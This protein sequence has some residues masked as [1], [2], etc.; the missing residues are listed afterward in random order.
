MTTTEELAQ[1]LHDE[2]EGNI[3]NIGKDRW[4]LTAR[5]LQEKQEEEK[6]VDF[7]NEALKAKRQRLIH[8]IKG[9]SDSCGFISSCCDKDVLIKYARERRTKYITCKKCLKMDDKYG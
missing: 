9:E 6:I 1:W 7:I 4:L 3:R 8:L 5:R 2:L